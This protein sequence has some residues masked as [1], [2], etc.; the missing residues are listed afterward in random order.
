M[1]TRFH[2]WLEDTFEAQLLLGNHWLKQQ[3]EKKKT[4]VKTELDRT[5]EGLY[6]DNGSCLD[7]INYIYPDTNSALQLIKTTPLT[8]TDGESQV[9][10][11]LAPNCARDLLQ[12]YPALP[13]LA[14]HT[15]IA[16]RK[17]TIQYTS[18]GPPRD[19]LRFIL[20]RVDR[21]G[22]S[23]EQ[24]QV[25]HSEHLRPLRCSK[26]V[27]VVLQQ[28]DHT[29][30]R[31]DGRCLQ[32][33][34]DAGADE[35]AMAGAV[36]AGRKS[37]VERTSPHS[38]M[39]HTQIAFG[40][41]LAVQEDDPQFIG[42]N[43]L[44]PVMAG[45][46]QRTDIRPGAATTDY[47][48]RMHLLTLI[49][50]LKKTSGTPKTAPAQGF[51]HSAF[52]KQ[53]AT[54]TTPAGPPTPSHQQ[55]TRSEAEN[56]TARATSPAPGPVM[57]LARISTPISPV[58]AESAEGPSKV[59][60]VSKQDRTGDGTV[61]TV[62][63]SWMKGLVF[64]SEA[65]K[66]PDK[67]KAILLKETSWMKLQVGLPPL[68]DG[69]MPQILFQT[70]RQMADEMAANE[71]AVVTD[72]QEHVDSSPDSSPEEVDP[73]PKSPRELTQD[74]ESP[75]SQVSWSPSPE[76]PQKP[77]KS[78]QGL[79]PD[80]SFENRVPD[81]VRNAASRPPVIDISDDDEPIAPPS[82]PPV[83]PVPADSDEEMEMDE[84]MPQALGEDV[85][86]RTQ[87]Q[88][89]NGS[90]LSLKPPRPQPQPVIQVKETPYRK[91]KTSQD[92]ATATSNSA[93]QQA[94]DSSGNSKNTP[95][96]IVYDTYQEQ[97]SSG[98]VL[99]E[100]HHARTAELPASN[101]Q[102]RSASA[103]SQQDQ[104]YED[105][106]SQ[107]HN[108]GAPEVSR[109]D[110]QLSP[111]PI[112]E[113]SRIRAEESMPTEV[114]NKMTVRSASSP[115]KSAQHVAMSP[116]PAIAP[117]QQPHLISGSTKRKHGNSPP[118]S[119]RVSKRRE[120]KIVGFGDNAP[121]IVDPMAAL[122]K[123]REESL[124]RFKEE[125]R[126]SR[127]FGSR[128]ESPSKLGTQQD[129]D[130]MDV[131]TPDSK[132]SSRAMS[133]RHRSLY[134][135]PSPTKLP[136]TIF[137]AS[138]P[139]ASNLPSNAQPQAASPKGRSETSPPTDKHV[140]LSTV[141]SQNG[142]MT[143]FESFKA[144]Y[145]EYTGD[146]DHF[147]RT[148]KEMYELELE[149]KMVPKW[150]WDDFIMRSISSDY[151]SYVVE[152]VVDRRETQEPYFRFYKDKIRDTLYTKGIVESKATLE[153]ALIELGVEL[154]RKKLPRNPKPKHNQRLSLPGAAN[155]HKKHTQDR[156]NANNQYRSRHS[157][158]VNSHTR[159][160]PSRQ[161]SGPNTRP[162][163]RLSSSRNSPRA[164][165]YA[166]PEPR[167]NSNPISPFDGTSHSPESGDPFR[168]YY[169]AVQRST[170]FTGSTAV[171]PSRQTE[172]NGRNR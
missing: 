137:S 66:V 171:S 50:G 123:D 161:P 31:E 170:S 160:L 11:H 134:E 48:R 109:V 167:L 168:D 38:K 61:S 97:T 119:R 115:T 92:I 13:H 98:S 141:D 99:I 147:G 106:S 105:T 3:H 70:I 140:P 120:I 83:A 150:Q 143:V 102:K 17:Y 158:P 40:T 16:V 35:Q 74:E 138:Q 37:S 114:M 108:L 56:E 39:P 32:S 60:H 80:S 81:G 26:P 157:L 104:A 122:R 57:E 7:I 139:V 91:G 165:S 71:D 129:T 10:A 12:R 172:P 20:H 43:R 59:H 79:P 62:E 101:L 132:P 55:A 78:C 124:R 144:T 118:R 117:S 155:Q 142:S 146:L 159:Q 2:A 127:S 64:N 149:D 116:S 45:N 96:P 111:T 133:P 69:N 73:S 47:E 34:T 63:C 52:G 125:K 25:V 4:G 44:E 54:D 42:V 110:L 5:W 93:S 153:R 130:A 86:Q 82:S 128:P 6:H 46:T 53:P 87:T 107:P 121:L 76:P 18:Y 84:S 163:S 51:V 90:P 154:P 131:D 72:S 126:S 94:Q 100:R 166:T 1:A 95:T 33:A 152:C 29:R 164:H 151:R 27:G 113:T 19:K 85:A 162:P 103:T 23:S 68:I 77:A 36:D 169:F 136:S 156:G 135:E 8:L 22:A 49:G 24:V 58:A 112:Y 15:A 28:L 14:E 145:S 65:L 9:I 67:Q 41:Q 75:T 148:C 88:R 21:L 89:V 30:A